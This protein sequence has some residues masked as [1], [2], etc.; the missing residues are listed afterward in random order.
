MSDASLMSSKNRIERQ[1]EVDEFKC[2]DFLP[3][4]G[5]EN[6]GTVNSSGVLVVLYVKLDIMLPFSFHSWSNL[7]PKFN[8]VGTV[9][10]TVT[11][12]RTNTSIVINSS[13]I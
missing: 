11:D 5:W 8:W 9:Q 1:S 6:P 2:F 4:P 3:L 13:P 7:G 10:Y 12:F